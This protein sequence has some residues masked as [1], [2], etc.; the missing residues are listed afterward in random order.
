M[1][2][3]RHD[4]SI[5]LSVDGGGKVK[6]ELQDVG[7]AGDKSIK[8]IGTASGKTSSK[9]ATLTARAS[10]L[11]TSMSALYAVVAAAGTAGGMREIVKLYADFE[12][13]LIGVGKTANLSGDKLASLGKDIDTLSKRI[14]VTT[15]ELLAIAQSAGQLGVKGSS[16]ILKFTETIAKLGSA[17]DLSGDEAAMA[18]ARIL[19]VTGEAMDTVDVLASVIV[20]LGNDSAA[21][22]SQIV[23]M[24]TEVARST[25]D[26]GVSSAQV[27]ALAAALVSVGV[28]AESGGSSVGRVMRMMD[29]AV[30]NG[31]D[32]MDVL[33]KIIGKTGSEIK[34]LFQQ[35]AMAAFALF[36]DGLKRIKDAGG[37]TA[38]SLD[39]LGLADQ[40]LLKTIPVLANRADLLTRAL[41]LAGSETANA[42]ALNVEAAKAF[43]ALNSQAELMWNNVTSLARSFGADL[44]PS[45][46]AIIKGLGD[47]ANQADI[48]YEKL[49]LLAQ[50]D[51]NFDGLS[52]DSTRTIVAEH[53]AELQIISERLKEQG[54]GGFMDDPLGW[55]RKDLLERQLKEKTA[56]YQQW[57][58]K[59]AWMQKDMNEKPVPK[60]D[61]ATSVPGEGD[62]SIKDALARKGNMEKIEKDLQR[63][64]FALTHEGADRIR[65]EYQRL[66]KDVE[67]LLAP[68]GGNQSRVDDLMTQAAAVRDT[69]LTKLAAREHENARRLAEA[70]RKVIENL[71]AEQ[72]ALAMT[73]RQ[74]SISQALRRLSAEATAA[75]RDQVRELADTLFDEHERI[76]A[77]NKAAQE[78]IQQEKKVQALLT[79]LRSAQEAYNAEVKELKDLRN[80]GAISEEEY[81]RASEDAYERMLR[82]SREWRHGVT[83]ALRDYAD[84]AGNAARQFEQVT[85]RSLRASEDA[86]VEWARTGKFSAADLF[87]TIAEEAMRAAVRM[88]VIK[89]FSGFLENLFSTIGSNMF[90]GGTSAPVGD[91]YPNAT[92]M[93]AH[94]GGVIGVDTLATR[95]VDPAVFNNAPRFHGG[96]VVGNE[97]PIIAMRGERVLNQAQQDNTARTI[98]GLAAL[99][100]PSG[101]EVSVKVNVYNQA[102]GTEA[103]AYSR[104][105]ANGN[106]GLDIVVEK[107]EGK[108]ARNIGRGDGLAPT[109][110]RRYGLNPAAGSY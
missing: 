75:E 15:D 50:G 31:G 19:N 44:A 37:S 101:P 57:A 34:T 28:Q 80:E 56:I 71:N 106:M 90:G 25:S 4:Y 30:R 70:N 29:D 68:D 38:E 27:S 13:G 98:A 51:F 55:V 8:R 54:D 12:A 97:V 23:T 107:V 42:T 104:K 64:L 96:G 60:T 87:N 10:T 84:E 49:K 62:E 110:E 36:I 43:A 20:A 45:V 22:E 6:A 69:K 9:L 59:L 26:F 73:D 89:P 92:T 79:G 103:T 85:T 16:N 61:T 105:D 35:D 67:A 47:L 40:R 99:P 14:P 24:A 66:A 3:T 86:F 95:L 76:K 11:R 74:R 91:F 100:R 102:P 88:A 94:T 7:R 52:L 72:D 17:S 21:T 93:V 1:G 39:A 109:L 41:A 78:T 2:K 83:R 108:L 18:L 53:Q 77:N 65:A 58:A 81:A 48:A 33:S 32:S 63:Q 46:I 5:R 82:A